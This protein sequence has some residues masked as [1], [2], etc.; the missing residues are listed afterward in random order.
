MREKT[1]IMQLV[2]WGISLLPLVLVLICYGKLPEQIPTH[3]GLGGQVTYGDKT[4]LWFISGL[5]IVLCVIFYG[6]ALIDPKKDNYRKFRAPY[7][8]IQ[9]MVELLLFFVVAVIIIESFWPKSVNVSTAICGFLGFLFIVMGNLMPKFRQNFFIGFRTPWTLTSEAVWNKTNRLGGR[10][11][12]GSGFVCV[13]GAL[14]PDD[15]WKFVMLMVPLIITAAVP[16]VMS[17]IWYRQIMKKQQV[18]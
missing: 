2:I 15:H 5:S 4:T 8:I 7:L 1:N 16:T 12:F 3:W 14:I 13:L 6:L 11:M 10:M 18:N 17:Y 9:L